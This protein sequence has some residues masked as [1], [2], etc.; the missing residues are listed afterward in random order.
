MEDEMN[1]F[2]SLLFVRFL[3]LCAPI[4]FGLY[5]EPHLFFRFDTPFWGLKSQWALE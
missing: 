5:I 4:N 1:R 2:I 3:M